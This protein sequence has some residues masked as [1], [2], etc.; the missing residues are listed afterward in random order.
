[1]QYGNP[2][3]IMNNTERLA[4]NKDLDVFLFCAIATPVYLEDYL[5]SKVKNL[6]PRLF[7]DHHQYDRMDMENLTASFNNIPSNNKILVT[8]E[9]DAVK[10]IP[11]REWIVAN[12]LPIYIIPVQTEFFPEDKDL[13]DGEVLN[14]VQRVS[15][16]YRPTF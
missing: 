10:L 3:S 16:P 4:L 15:P 9:K 8:T 14:Y 6:Y 2:Y 13:F 5:K 12:K 11:F 1:M 7:R